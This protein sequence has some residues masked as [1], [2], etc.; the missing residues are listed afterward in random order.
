LKKQLWELNFNDGRRIYYTIIPE[1][2]LILLLGGNKN[3]QKKDI[4]KARK[5]IAEAQ[6][7]EGK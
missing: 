4:Q 2:N 7:F 1:K 3:G 6:K 5:I